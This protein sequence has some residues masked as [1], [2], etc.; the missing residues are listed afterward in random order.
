VPEFTEF[1]E[2]S[3]SKLWLARIRTS[4]LHGAILV[5]LVLSFMEIEAG[6]NLLK[7]F[8]A[9]VWIVTLVLIFRY[10]DYMIQL[11]QE[12]ELATSRAIYYTV[13]YASTVISLAI[14]GWFISAFAW[15][16]SCVWHFYV[17]HKST[18]LRR[19]P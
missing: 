11:Y 3:G 8:T 19:E 9:A 1:S 15:L 4:L 10:H 7:F 6:Y 16:A 2:F 5:S 12:K 17:Y 13:F 18:K 14:M